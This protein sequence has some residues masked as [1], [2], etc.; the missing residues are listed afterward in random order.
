MPKIP[1][2]LGGR[3][4]PGQ[5]RAVVSYEDAGTGVTRAANAQTRNAADSARGFQTLGSGIESLAAEMQQGEDRIR[6]RND[7]VTRARDFGAVNERLDAELRRLR[8]EADMS[9]P[10]TVEGY[11]KFLDTEIGKAVKGHAGSD[12]SRMSLQQRLLEARTHY[13]GQAASIAMEEG[14]KQ[15]NDHMGAQLNTITSRAWTRPGSLVDNFRTWDR[16][17]D[18]MA[19]A[20]GPSQERN[21][22]RAGR[23]RIA[24][25]SIGSLIAQGGIEDAKRLM[26]TPGLSE[27][28]GEQAQTRIQTQ[29]LAADRAINDAT[30]AGLRKRLELKA[31][32]GRD[33]TESEVLGAIIPGYTKQGSGGAQSPLG[34][35]AADRKAGLI[36]DAEYEAAVKKETAG[37]AADRVTDTIGDATSATG[38]RVV[39]R[40]LITRGTPLTPEELA[41]YPPGPP[42]QGLNV[43][44][45]PDG[46]IESITTGRE[47]PKTPS[48]MTPGE[49]GDVEK[50]LIAASGDLMQMSDAASRFKPEFHTFAEQ[51]K[52]SFAALKERAGV[53]LDD[54]RKKKLGEI[55]DY[56]ARISKSQAKIRNELFGSALTDNEKVESN[57]FLIADTD[58]P[59]QAKS[60]MDA[61]LDMTR[62][63]VARLHYISKRGAQLKMEDVPLDDMPRIIQERWDALD[64]QFEQSGMDDPDI[65][66][67]A[68]REQVGR[69]FGLV[70]G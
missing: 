27:I 47:T 25:A 51:G 39:P 53:E 38:T 22:R 66:K 17:V 52:N 26:Q 15:V 48:G 68:V 44:T 9:R 69:E 43:K 20:L 5:T 6:T 40:E 21:L 63:A 35:L 60:K 3:P 24:E 59:T 61:F 29:L 7:A 11:S 33:P 8:T 45:R 19:A 64:K 57:K 1:D 32:L 14:H 4:A 31:A 55:S 62:K 16:E 18:D 56:F 28:L 2:T 34:K 65:R 42:S 10:E 30:N 49:Q 67:R 13:A 37:Q 41:K 50:K 54:K 58:S 36:S 23:E 70:G 12:E 46:T